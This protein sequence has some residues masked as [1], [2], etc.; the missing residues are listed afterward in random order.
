MRFFSFIAV[1]LL[2]CSAVF[3]VYAQDTAPKPATATPKYV[4]PSSSTTGNPTSSKDVFPKLPPSSL[5]NNKSIVGVW[6]LL[7]VYE[8]PSGREIT[9][10]TSRP[11]QYVVFE[12]D[13]R[14]GDYISSLRDVSANEVRNSVIKKKDVQQ[15]ALN[16]SGQIYF[17]KNAIAI[18]SL[19]C[20]L[21]SENQ[22][23]FE[24]G[25]MLLMPPKNTGSGRMVKIYQKIPV[26]DENT[27]ENKT[28]EGYK[29]SA[30]VGI[31]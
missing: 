21:V 11:L 1:T 20:F 31:Q 23:P 6:K 14:Y 22:G 7:M 25:Q 18:D 5:C 15:F 12:E 2:S 3:D 4:A 17:Y 9:L 10:Y 13:S 26:F 27:D 29:T 28:P 30:P 24:K 16:I 8:V 19:A